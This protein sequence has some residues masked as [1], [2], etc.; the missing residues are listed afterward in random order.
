MLK[1]IVAKSKPSNIGAHS[2]EA[3]K[4]ILLMMTDEFWTDEKRNC[5]DM[6]DHGDVSDHGSDSV[7]LHSNFML[8]DSEIHR[9]HNFGFKE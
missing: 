1:H 4:N 3:H 7:T 8:S 9:T 2:V 6:S 5:H